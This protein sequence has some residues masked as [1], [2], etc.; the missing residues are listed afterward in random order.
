MI[1]SAGRMDA[2]AHRILVKSSA[3]GGMNTLR[4]WGG[5]IFY[6]TAFYDA[7]DEYGVLVYH[8]MQ[9]ASTGG[10]AHGPIV[11]ATQEAELRHQIRR[12]SHHPAIVLWDGNNE[13]PVNAWQ[14][15]GVFAT[16]VMTIVAQEDQSRAVWP[17]SPAVGWATGVDR[18]YQTPNWES[19]LG[20]TTKGG[21]HSWS[22]GIESHAPYQTGGGWPT[23]NGGTDD[24]CFI[25]NGMG[26]GVNLP[27]IFTPPHGIE[28]PPA[29]QHLECY[30]TVKAVCAGHF[31]NVSAC[32]DC[33]NT[34]PGAW[35][36]IKPACNPFPISEF[37]DSCA[38]FFPTAATHAATGISQS[39]IYASEFG[40][41][42]SSSFESM[43]GT[44]SKQH[45]GVHGGMK[46][47]SCDDDTPGSA[48][49]VG[50]HACNGSN[51]MAERNYACDGAIHLFFG[52][53]T[54]VD[55]DATGELAFKG[56]MYQC[57]LVQAVVLKQASDSHLDLSR[58]PYCTFCTGLNILTSYPLR[59]FRR[60]TRRGARK[61]R[62]G[63]WSGCS[64]RS[65][66]R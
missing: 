58:A 47:D 63:T 16:F 61:T 57:Q 33:R 20:M 27:S 12:L 18:L 52:N 53:H 65:G 41:T 19:P 31:Q 60:S 13:I 22:G 17:S 9:Y 2:E 38:S 14:P 26:N 46:A 56:Q 39:N 62:L 30:T 50:Q 37:H 44:L 32:K 34:V 24:T 1:G 64:T 51:V 4:V 15:S 21:G 28:P 23:V 8:D 10:G 48:R 40:T 59:L 49:C 55:L 66:L 54:M 35:G 25:Q 7:C 5:G 45:W 43:S 11:T 3:D 42:G 6:P 36:K 29:P